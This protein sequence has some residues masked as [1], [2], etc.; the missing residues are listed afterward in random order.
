LI[1]KSTHPDSIVSN[2]NS[3]ASARGL[4][5]QYRH[6]AAQSQ[7]GGMSAA[8]ESRLCIVIATSP[9]NGKA[10]SYVPNR[11]V[12]TSISLSMMFS[13]TV[14]AFFNTSFNIGHHVG[15]WHA[16]ITPA[17]VEINLI[18]RRQTETFAVVDPI[19]VFTLHCLHPFAGRGPTSLVTAT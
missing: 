3:T 2:Y 8:G 1:Q 13:L 15:V 4:L 5:Q 12:G 16:E 9:E 6:I 19:A 11:C 7:S 10:D 18:V 14:T 17:Q